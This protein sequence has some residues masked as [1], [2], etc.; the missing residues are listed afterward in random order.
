VSLPSKTIVTHVQNKQP[1]MQVWHKINRNSYLQGPSSSCTGSILWLSCWTKDKTT[2][3]SLS[4]HQTRILEK[5]SL[6]PHRMLTLNLLV[7]L[8]YEVENQ[9]FSNL[10]ER[11]RNMICFTH[12]SFIT[13]SSLIQ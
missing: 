7:I 1:C 2:L 3:S 13:N 4:E 11:K 12:L 6:P 9:I 10:K 5:Q 8:K